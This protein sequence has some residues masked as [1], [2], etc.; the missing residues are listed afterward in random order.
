MICIV[1]L[2]LAIDVKGLFSG[3]GVDRN[4]RLLVGGGSFVLGDYWQLLRLL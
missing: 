4:A 1:V 3:D 2:V